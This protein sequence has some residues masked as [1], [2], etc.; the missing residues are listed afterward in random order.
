MAN[1][2][3]ELDTKI[4]PNHLN[5]KINKIFNTKN[6]K[7]IE[8]VDKRIFNL[9]FAGTNANKNKLFRYRFF[10]IPGLKRK[11][12]ELYKVKIPTMKDNVG[13]VVNKLLDNDVKV[14]LHGGTLRDFF[15]GKEKGTDI[16]LVFDKKLEDIQ[17]ICIKEDFPC[18][19]DK[20]V[21]KFQYILF[22]GDKGVSLEGVNMHTTFFVPLVKHEFT[23]SD[24]A[25][26]LKNNILI[27][28]TGKGMEDAVYRRIRITPPEKLW[29]QWAQRDFKKPLRYYKLELIN[30][31]PID[32]KTGAF[33]RDYINDNFE[34]VYM[35]EL[36]PGVSR[37][38]HFLIVNISQGEITPEGKIIL[39]PLKK[40]LIEYMKLF[41]TKI[42]PE[43]F[44][45]ITE[46]IL[47]KIEA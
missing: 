44:K 45:Q 12:N 19:V 10:Y 43:Y 21:P 31:K 46:V 6:I 37:I 24:L 41:K 3:E 22:G 40:R 5:G 47:D 17:E 2:V 36:Y 16:D 38:L 39:G 1:I 9:I 26:D 42:K 13:E 18:P 33:I 32:K 23:V 4:L 20:A 14:F 30:F 27:D 29:E 35:G 28:I 11:V 7:N 8:I 34:E 15:L 25:Y